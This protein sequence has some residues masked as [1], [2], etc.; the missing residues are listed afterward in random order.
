MSES[1]EDTEQFCFYGKP[2]DPYDED[3][4]PRKRPITVEEQIATDAQG[5]RRFHGAFTGG[6]SAG[7]FNTV[8]S[9]E[10]WLPSEFKSSRAEKSEKIHQRPEDYMDDEDLGEDGI[11]PQV[12]RATD[13]YNTSRKRKKQIFADG[14]IPGEPVLHN[15]ITSGNE[16]IGY[17]LLKNLRIKDRRSKKVEAPTEKSY[18]CQMPKIDETVNF[19][20]SN[21]YEIPAIYKEFLAKPKNNTFGLGYSGLDKSHFSLFPA[22]N[23]TQFKVTDRNNKK[24]SIAGQAFGVGAFE[25]EDD[26]IY[27]K[28]DMSKYDF[29][30]AAEKEKVQNKADSSKLVLGVFE[31]SKLTPFLKNDTKYPPPSIPHSFTGKHKVRRSRFEPIVEEA[32]K[33]GRLNPAI[34]AKY[35]GENCDNEY[36]PSRVLST[37]KQNTHKKQEVADIIPKQETSTSVSSS[38]DCYLS[39]KFVSSSKKEDVNNILQ[40]AEKLE[41]KTAYGTDQMR[42][43]VRMKMFGPLTR[44]TIDWTP[45]G[46]LCKRFN[47]PEPFADRP[48]KSRTRTKNI[49]F[50]YQK[51]VEELNLQPGLNKEDTVTETDQPSNEGNSL[52]KDESANSNQSKENN[53]VKNE[54]AESSKLP[55]PKDVTEKIGL[56]T[57]Q[58]LFKAIFMSSDS[59][60]ENDDEVEKSTTGSDETQENIRKEELKSTVLSDQLIPKIKPLKEGI[61]SG[62]SFHQ[63]VKP[64][65]KQQE[66]ESQSEHTQS[67][68]PEENNVGS[69][70]PKIP[71]RLLVPEKTETTVISSDS[72]E[73]WVEK[74]DSHNNK[75]KKHKKHKSK[76][77]KHKHEKKKK[78]HKSQV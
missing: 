57:Q 47:V 74:D 33:P 73:D 16:T 38:L 44:T 36:T 37:P 54:E 23:K 52:I 35:L 3:A 39:D 13:D 24:L 5:R 67:D 55:R 27:M 49:I 64:E 46:L 22:E 32:P 68:Q 31:R 78:S 63:F 4:V 61:L 58:D 30:L 20:D 8:G 45:C 69:Y 40:V 18:G 14:P 9:L 6:F 41:E 75:K 19:N 26:D 25:N 76:H 60:S 10:G 72:E 59:E 15:I 48:Q 21:Q 2:L 56:E 1:D 53:E 71:D 62:I 11:A 50:E 43:A 77:K 17:M 28:E 51:H 29:E 42:E 7:F 12:V 66:I 65:P 34:R 70:G